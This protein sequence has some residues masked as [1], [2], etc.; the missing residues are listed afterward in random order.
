MTMQKLIIG[1]FLFIGLTA[2]KLPISEEL[3]TAFKTGNAEKI[4]TH[5]TD[6]IDMSIP[7]N[8]G[9]FSK[10]Q[11]TQILKTFFSKNKPS[12]F[13]VVHNGDSKNS[14][15]YSIGSLTTSS[16][17]YRVYILYE[18]VTSTNTILELRIESE[19]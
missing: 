14:S 7:D 11:A 8:E 15:H 9:V 2:S 17:S 10:T 13:K 4:S 6:P 12:G 3:S 1:I 18:K 16:G 5:F 19:E